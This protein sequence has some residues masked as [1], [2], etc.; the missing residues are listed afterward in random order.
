M[1]GVQTCALPIS[2]RATGLI[3]LGF[4]WADFA[5]SVEKRMLNSNLINRRRTS[6]SSRLSNNGKEVNNFEMTS[7]LRTF[8]I[9]DL[10]SEVHHFVFSVDNVKLYQYNGGGV[11]QAREGGE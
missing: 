4:K 8:A 6:L 10:P 9:L 2:D 3:F 5:P 1:T 11:W 7:S